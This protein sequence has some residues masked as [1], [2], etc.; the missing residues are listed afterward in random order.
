MRA[1][2]SVSHWRGIYFH[3]VPLGW[4]LQA[5][6][7]DVRVMCSGPEPVSRAGLIPVPVLKSFDLMEGERLARAE[8]LCPPGGPPAGAPPAPA[9][10]RAP[11]DQHAPFDLAAQQESYRRAL[12]ANLARNCDAAVAF[13][14]SW[15]PD[16]VVHDLMSPEGVL[17]AQVMKV[18]SIY[19]SL[20]LFGSTEA[21][22]HDRSGSF[23]RHGVHGWD[24]SRIEYA[25]DP[26]PDMMAPDMGRALRMPI[27]YLPYN[28]PGVPAAWMSEPTARPRICVIWSRS[29]TAIFGA[30]LPVLRHAV[31]ASLATGAE[32]VLTAGPEEAALLGDLPDDVR[33]LTD[34][35]LHLLLEHCDAIIHTGSVGPMMTA[36]GLPQLILALTDDGAEM[37]RRFATAGSALVLPG[38]ASGID[39]VTAA[40]RRLCHD[41]DLREAARRVG[42]ALAE[43]PTAAEWVPALETLARTG[44]LSA[45]DAPSA[46]DPTSRRNQ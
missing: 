12:H 15:H 34:Q 9:A 3:M 29:S 16:L 18:P 21:D 22:L 11:G 40:V 2:F 36:A 20:G 13:A 33:V 7:H 43:H 30:G 24:R 45:G 5:A 26:T 42:T 27:R 8:A 46:A 10:G 14:R 23:P 25:L 1:L 37:G 19:Y 4:A 28:G 39:D 41:M 31:E 38:L 17:A 32:V 6:G 44:T 35:P